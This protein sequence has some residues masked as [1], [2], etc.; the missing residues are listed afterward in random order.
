MNEH[1]LRKAL[2]SK[3]LANYAKDPNTRIVDELGLRHGAARIDVAV[4]NGIIH[5]FELKSEK[6]NLKRLPR[7]IEIYNSVLDKVTLVVADHHVNAASKMIPEWWGI[8]IATFDRRKRILFE[9]QRS[10]NTNPSVDLV[11][12]CKLLW[13]NEALGLLRELGEAE[14][15]RYA[16]RASIY[17][18]LA[19]VGDSEWIR[20]RVR[21][22]LKFRASWRFVSPQTSDD[23]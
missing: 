11:S 7:Q 23:D 6:D 4:V 2:R 19:L 15:V 8:M 22:Q 21:H 3:V 18:H 1:K 13:R 12:V 10:A 9:F 20:E 16:T 17:A 5:G 14:C